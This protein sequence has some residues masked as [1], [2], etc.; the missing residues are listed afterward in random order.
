MLNK[1]CFRDLKFALLR[2][3]LIERVLSGQNAAIS[4]CEKG[5]CWK[6]ALILLQTEAP[7]TSAPIVHVKHGR[8]PFAPSSFLFL[9]VRQGQ[10]TLVASLLLV[11]GPGAPS[12]FLFLVLDR[13]TGH[14]LRATQ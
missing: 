14:H 1:H 10:E 3:L 9:E 6:S 4:A 7:A 2:L 5:S 11:V 8:L 12:S 13:L